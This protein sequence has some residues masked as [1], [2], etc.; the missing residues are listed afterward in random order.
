MCVTI[1]RK[2]KHPGIYGKEDIKSFIVEKESYYITL[3]RYIEANAK[4]AK[5]VKSAEDWDYGSLMEREY[6]H[7]DILSR[8]YMELYEEWIEYVNTPIK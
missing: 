3:I 8:P 1:I 2:I 6:K 7:R 4:K 5:L